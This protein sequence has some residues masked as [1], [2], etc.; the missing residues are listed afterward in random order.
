ME[1]TFQNVLQRMRAEYYSQTGV[2]DGRILHH[3]LGKR[4]GIITIYGTGNGERLQ[5]DYLRKLVD[6]S[7][8]ERARMEFYGGCERWNTV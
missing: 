3:A 6:E 4:D 2:L 7:I 5:P 8:Y 1:E